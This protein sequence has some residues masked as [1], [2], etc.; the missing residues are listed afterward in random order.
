MKYTFNIMLYQDTFEPICFKPLMVLNTTELYSSTRVRMAL[1]NTQG[2]SVVGKLVLVQLIC[3]KIARSHSNIRDS[4]LCKGHDCEEVLQVWGNRIVGPL[5]L[6]F[7]LCLCMTVCL[8]VCLPACS[9]V[10]LSLSLSLTP[11]P[12]PP[13]F[14]IPVVPSP[15]NI[16]GWRCRWLVNVSCYLL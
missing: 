16:I 10:C 1:V 15:P 7:L 12:S 14:P 8:P 11:P 2:H 3:C 4:W 6:L 13:L 9:P 5:I